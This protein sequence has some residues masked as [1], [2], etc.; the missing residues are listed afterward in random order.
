LPDPT[1]WR[2]PLRRRRRLP[3]PSFFRV[4][5]EQ[6]LPRRVPD[7]DFLL[8]SARPGDAHG[9]LLLPARRFWME[10]RPSRTSGRPS[11]PCHQ[12]ASGPSMACWWA[13]APFSRPPSLRLAKAGARRALPGAP[14]AG[15]TRPV[16]A[17]ALLLP[18]SPSGLAEHPSKSPQFMAQ[19]Q[20]RRS[21][22]SLMKQLL[23]SQTMR[24]PNGSFWGT[25]PYL[26]QRFYHI[27]GVP[28]LSPMSSPCWRFVLPIYTHY[29]TGIKL[30][31]AHLVPL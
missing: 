4:D 8:C 7:Q 30:Y 18:T 24:M 28:G 14:A 1:F 27:V 3:A 5:S 26:T 31:I 16:M 9:A 15:A 2:G 19:V 21:G 29:L 23:P 6:A 25:L 22:T 13:P 17:L 20:M 11:A 10:A 12:A